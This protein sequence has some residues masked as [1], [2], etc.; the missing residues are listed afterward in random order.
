MIT[1]GGVDWGHT[2]IRVHVKGKKKKEEEERT[3]NGCKNRPE[4]LLRPPP[5]L[6]C[7][8]PPGALFA[9]ADIERDLSLPRPHL[10]TYVYY[11]R[12]V[13]VRVDLSG[14]KTV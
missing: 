11:T 7:C 1:P 8:C 5:P 2:I 6:P 14:V 9:A 13:C 3:N 4:V 12:C 10:V